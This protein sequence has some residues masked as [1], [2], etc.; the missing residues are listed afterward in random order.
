MPAKPKVREY[1]LKG[2]DSGLYLR[3]RHFCVEEGITIKE[4]MLQ[5]IRFYLNHVLGIEED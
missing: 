5:A 4:F 2:I 3:I 1:L